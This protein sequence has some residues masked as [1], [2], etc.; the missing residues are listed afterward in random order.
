M[1]PMLQSFLA[2]LS[3]SWLRRT[4]LRP[5]QE[6][7]DAIEPKPRGPADEARQR[8]ERALSQIQCYKPPPPR[9]DDIASNM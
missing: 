4:K 7:T 8:R 3:A 1:Q 2:E 9:S 6:S 5:F